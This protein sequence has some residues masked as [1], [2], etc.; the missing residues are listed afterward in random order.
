[1]N[2]REEFKTRNKQYS[3]LEKQIRCL[4]REQKKIGHCD[5]VDIIGEAV[6]EKLGLR[7]RRY[8]NGLGFFSKNKK[9]HYH[10]KPDYYFSLAGFDENLRSGNG[11]AY[12][13]LPDD[14][15]EIAQMLIEGQLGHFPKWD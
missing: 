13:T 2:W 3:I 10:Y 15:D 8:L 9:G 6:G 5:S 7:Y 14:T 4:E 12:V 1:M 11:E